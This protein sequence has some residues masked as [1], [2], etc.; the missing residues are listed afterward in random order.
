MTS[1]GLGS[2]E[3]TQ[4]AAINHL[5][6]SELTWGWWPRSP[7]T[8]RGGVESCHRQGSAP[9]GHRLRPRWLL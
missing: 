1:S 2:T 3:E 9:G 5:P 6:S 8:P 7:A 4:F